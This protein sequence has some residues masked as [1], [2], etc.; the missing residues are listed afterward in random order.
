MTPDQHITPTGAELARVDM[1]NAELRRRLAVARK[2]L[3]GLS[4]AVDAFWND[5]ERPSIIR[6]RSRSPQ[7]VSE[8]QQRA[9][10]VIAAIDAPMEGT[11]E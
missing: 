7:R 3:V 9:K 10:D 2:A 5:E 11:R 6:M 1:E 8:A 4:N